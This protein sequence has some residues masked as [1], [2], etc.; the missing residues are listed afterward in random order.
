MT[1]RSEEQEANQDALDRL[2]AAVT[3]DYLAEPDKPS[4]RSLAVTSNGHVHLVKVQGNLLWF[5]NVRRK[6]K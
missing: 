6:A 5:P 3:E 4:V 2:L 1:S